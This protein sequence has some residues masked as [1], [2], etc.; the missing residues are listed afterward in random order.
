[1]TKLR[2]QID[3]TAFGIEK[4]DRLYYLNN[5]VLSQS[6]NCIVKEW[7]RILGHCNVKDMLIFEDIIEG[8]KITHKGGF[9]CEICKGKINI[10]ICGLL[11]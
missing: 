7:H 1:M 5:T 6:S 10:V 2:I 4:E 11:F 8:T 9:D 3:G